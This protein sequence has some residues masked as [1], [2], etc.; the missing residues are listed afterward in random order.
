V[1]SLAITAFPALP[2]EREAEVKGT[3]F[4]PSQARRLRAAHPRRH[5]VRPAERR[6]RTRAVAQRDAP[7][8]L[9]A[10]CKSSRRQPAEI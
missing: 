5:R 4:F 9:A 3:E 7:S 10:A 1:G 8:T 6:G 2:I